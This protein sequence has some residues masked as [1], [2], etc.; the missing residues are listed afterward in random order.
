MDGYE[1]LANAIIIQAAKDYRAARKKLRRTRLSKEA[2]YKAEAEVQSVERFFR[3]DWFS[4]LSELDGEFILRK[5]Q[6]E[7]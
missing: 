2:R 1:R 4:C 3:S 6:E 7:T 5:L